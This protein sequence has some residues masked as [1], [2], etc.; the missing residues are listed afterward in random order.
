M[1]IGQISFMQMT[2]PATTPYGVERRS[3]RSTRASRARRR[4]ATSRTSRAASDRSRHGRHRLRR[5]ARRA[6]AARARP[7]GARA[8]P[9]P[10]ARRRGSRPGAPSS[11]KATS[12]IRRR[13]ARRCAGVDAVVHLVAIIKGSPRRLRAG[14]GAGHARPRRRCEGGR[15]AAASCSR[16]R[17]G[18]TS[19]RRTRCPYYR[20]EVG[21]GARGQ[22]VRAR[23]RDLPAELRLRQGRRRAADVRAAR[24]LR[25]GDADRRRRARSGCS[26]SGSRT[27]PSTSR[28]RV[29][30]P[31]AANRTFELGGPDAPTWNEFWD[32]LKRV[33]GARRPSLHVP[34]RRSC[35]CRRR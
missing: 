2:E 9:R 14:H 6:R 24:A 23:A 35:A 1:K 11:S 12:P 21:D 10:R 27:S 18:S 28:A 15:R 17:S 19:G 33:L 31:A 16:A 20:R 29:D 8:R 22:G 30:L 13:C 3:A 7:A 26:R 5:P 32:R 34:V 25:A 4:A